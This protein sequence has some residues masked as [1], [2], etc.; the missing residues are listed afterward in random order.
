RGVRDEL[1]K[2]VI[3]GYI[4]DISEQVLAHRRLAELEL[5]YRSIF[6]HSVIG[7]FQTTAD[8]HYLAA[9]PALAK[10]Y[11]YD[12]PAELIASL[13]D[14]ATCL[15][16]DPQRR[17]VFK[18]IIRERGFV[19]DFESEVYRRDGS[20]IW[21][22]ENAHMVMSQ[23]GEVLYYEG[24]VEDITERRMAQ[25]QLQFQ[26]THD[27]LTGLPNRNLLSDRL[28]RAIS[29]ARRNG[30]SVAVVFIDLDNFKF[31]NDSLGHTVGDQLLQ[32]MAVRL[33]RSL[34]EADTVARYGGDE[35]VLILDSFGGPDILKIALDRVVEM[36]SEPMEL[37]G[38]ELR[39]GC[40][41]GVSRFPDDGADLPTLLRHA[42]AAM[43]H[44]KNQGKGQVAFYTR[45][46]N[47]AASERLRLEGALRRAIQSDE[48]SVVYQPKVGISGQVQGFEALVRWHSE[49]FGS[50][51]PVRFIPLVEEIGLMLPMTEFVLEA[52]CRE[53]MGWR[54]RRLGPE[55]GISVAVNL[56]ATL[57]GEPDLVDRVRDTLRRTG[58]PARLL[59]LEITES[60]L[61]GD[62]D[63]TVRVLNEFKTLGLSIAVDDFGTGYSSL[64]YLKRFPL[65]VLKIDRSMVTGCECGGDALAIPRAVISLGHSLGLTV[66]AEGVELPEQRNVLA[67][68]GCDEYQGYLYAKPMRPEETIAYLE[69]KTARSEDRAVLSEP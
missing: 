11:G 24:T 67:S 37:E 59:Q 26:A 52:A 36:I 69:T 33:R 23:S 45:Q 20:R 3:E 6:D 8:G 66:V 41:L 40:S 18:R 55:S 25:E 29:L 15:Y 42:D 64:A 65:D 27:S 4:A 56:S 57:L 49:E 32:E 48:F 28:E 31:V 58:L 44:A 46:L 68:L 54:N 35:F 30:G 7:I 50:V 43:Y 63:L 21:I 34:R 13:Q 5:R 51:S 38:H 22:A 10:L 9:N 62:V 39:V 19:S 61:M 14:I 12:E 47:A 1:G 2:R 17:D 60:V 53:A 16:V